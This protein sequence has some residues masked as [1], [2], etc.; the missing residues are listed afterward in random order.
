MSAVLWAT[1]SSG[2]HEVAKRLEKAE[3]K[4]QLAPDG[5]LATRR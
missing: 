2:P 4:A 3:F 5:V 1:R